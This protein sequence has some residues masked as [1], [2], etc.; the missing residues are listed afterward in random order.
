L[1]PAI[2]INAARTNAIA[3]LL[4]RDEPNTLSMRVAWNLSL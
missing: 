4:I 3:A 1:Q 2:A